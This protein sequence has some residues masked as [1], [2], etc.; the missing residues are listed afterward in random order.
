MGAIGC[1]HHVRREENEPM[2]KKRKTTDR[3]TGSGR[4]IWVPPE[5]DSIDDEP[6]VPSRYMSEQ[7]HRVVS[8]M[9][10]D[11]EFADMEEM[12]RY[13]DEHVAGRKLDDLM[14]IIEDDPVEVAQTVAFRAMDADAY[15]DALDLANRALALDPECVDALV[16]RETCLS[17]SPDDAIAR[18]RAVIDRVER[19]WGKQ[20]MRETEGH[21]WGEI[22]TRPYM[23]A[24]QD[25][26]GLLS[27]E[28]HLPE[29]IDACR[30]MLRLNP[31]DNQ[32]AR[33][34]LL[35]LLLQVGD[36]AG[37]EELTRQYEKDAGAIFMWGRALA[38]FQAEGRST[39]AAGS[40]ARAIKANPYVYDFLTGRRKPP[41]ERPAY[42]GFG[43]PAEAA[44]FLQ[45]QGMAWI[46]TPGALDWLLDM[47]DA[48]RRAR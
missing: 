33:E 23:R 26:V 46:E 29:A 10:A 14:T 35:G 18:V 16:T 41:E 20:Y 17:T 12:Q 27:N 24:R 47:K 9:M 44:F 22:E 45:M 3:K 34:M 36:A 28:G 32:G 39:G 31:G 2:S 42:H 1:R 25:L 43:D 38:C 30:T 6:P 21:F 15:E 13:L 8:K 48:R 11:K 19:A 5:R 40:L 4:G 7:F 37:A